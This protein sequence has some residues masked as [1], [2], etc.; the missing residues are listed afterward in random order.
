[1]PAIID[2]ESVREDILMAFRKCID[3]KPI[4]KITLRDVAEEAGI[5]HAKLLY[6]FNSRD[7]MVHEYMRFS[8]GY[9]IDKYEKWFD[10]HPRSN[11]KTDSDY[12]N[13][14]F[15]YA[16]IGEARET[17]LN[18][19]IQT[20]VLSHYD[21]AAKNLLE[22]EY[23]AWLDT[24]RRC[25]KKAFGKDCSTESA[26]SIMVVLSGLFI[27]RYNGALT[28]ELN[29]QIMSQLTKLSELSDK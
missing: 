25:L 4:D 22:E 8:R 3:K 18:S 2:K 26:E 11:Y 9:L 10:E 23:G 12:F 20:Y 14:L 16:A 21:D 29:G 7:E 17:Q 24:L 13:D 1:M 5:S 19:I 15:D 6:Y 27:C 28:G